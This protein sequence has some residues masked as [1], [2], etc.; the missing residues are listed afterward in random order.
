AEKFLTSH[1]ADVS[2]LELAINEGKIKPEEILCIIGKT[3]G[4]G[5]RNDFTRD[6]AMMGLEQLLG[7][8]LKLAK[9][10]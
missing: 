8:R 6:L 1:P 4:N 5:G 9:H 3:E 2:G 10:E 7:P